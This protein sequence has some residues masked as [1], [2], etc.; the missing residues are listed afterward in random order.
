MTTH[1]NKYLEALRSLP[2]NRRPEGIRARQCANKL[3]S[4]SASPLLAVGRG[5]GLSLSRRLRGIVPA[6]A[7]L[8]LRAAREVRA[9]TEAVGT[10]VQFGEGNTLVEPPPV[11]VSLTMTNSFTGF[12]L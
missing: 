5:E 12:V 8:A 4:Y 6:L 11:P 9:F 10:H 7:P 1:L 2:G 3:L